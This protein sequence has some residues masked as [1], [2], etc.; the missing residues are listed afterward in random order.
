MKRTILTIIAVFALVQTVMAEYVRPDMAA[1]Y[2]QGILG[3]KES[4]VPANMDYSRVGSRDGQDAA[5]EFYVFNNPGGGW[6]I[7]AAD[8][9]VSP[10]IGYSDKGTFNLS[11]MPDNLKWWMDGVADVIDDVRQ[12][13]D[14]ASESVRMAWESLRA[15]MSPVKE[16]NKSYIETANWDQD[17]PFNDAC[18]IVNGETKRAATGCIATAMAIIMRHNCWPS[19]GK[20]VIG[21]YTT[22]T[23]QTYILPYDLEQ[24]TYDWD[25]MPLTNGGAAN[26]QWTAEQKKQVAQ[27]MLDC[28]VAV[29]MDYTS[30]ASSA[31]SGDVVKAMKENMSY[32]D[33][34]SLVSRSSYTLDKW[35][36]LIKNEIDQ[37][38]VVYY[39]G[40]G[41]DGGHAFVC[42]GY[43]N[44]SINPK[45][46]INWGWGGDCNG[47]YTLD[48]AIPRYNVNF[49]DLQEAIIGLAPDT[50][51]VELEETVGLV[52]INY[53]GFYGIEPLVPAD[54][55]VGSP[56]NFYVGW[57]MNN[58]NRDISAEFKVCLEDKD[59]NVRQEGWNLKMDIPASDGYIYSDETEKTVLTVSPELSD[60][61]RLYAKDSQDTWKPMHGNYD[62]L[63]DVDGVICG[64]IQDPVI[65][66]PDGCAAGQ[67]IELSLSLGFTHTRSVKWYLNDTAVNGNKVTLG[68]G[69]NVIRADVEYL[70]DSTGSIY[71]TLQLE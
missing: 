21:G 38:R 27:L 31:A 22:I 33:K 40:M 47:Y 58:E 62:I 61:F 16:G 65:I 25:N 42:D 54:I 43:D 70:D 60:H 44:D 32:S 69:K 15:G 71:R 3:M 13:G 6:V 30:D 45:L 39:A 46:R 53:N 23:K 18:P 52:C 28:G 37:G 59:G 20:G 26:S 19:H 12:S 51:N 10:V 66:V 68:Q 50:A 29:K 64:V 63:P 48:L 34:V 1:R 11:G 7:I 2:A 35:F 5:P 8:D 4:P 55:T 57:F 36:S 17:E 67:E 41:E 14:G 24:N 56:M 49:S 9:R